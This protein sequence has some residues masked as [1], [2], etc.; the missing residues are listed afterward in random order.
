MT[1]ER[2]DDATDDAINDAIVD[3]LTGEMAAG[4]RAA[5]AARVRE[6]AGLARRVE[7][8]RAT[9]AETRAW[10]AADPPGIERAD[11]LAIPGL[12]TSVG[13]ARRVV[14][15]RPLW[16]AGM[17]A[18]L[19]LGGFLIGRASGPSGFTAGAPA[20]VA[21]HV[22]RPETKDAD[23]ATPASERRQAAPERRVRDQNGRLVIETTLADSGAHAVWVIDGA[24][25][26]AQVPQR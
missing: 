12:V 4:E 17:A 14:Q 3:Y 22:Q 11:A 9:L 5:F 10:L 15:F 13:A 19:L 7:A 8:T 25:R 26:I 2:D 20:N 16:Q 23:A 24:A 21:E 18:A 6:D 1:D